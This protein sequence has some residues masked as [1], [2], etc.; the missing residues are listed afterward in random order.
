MIFED[1]TRRSFLKKT[2]ALAVGISAT[3]LFSGLAHAAD[4]GEVALDCGN[5]GGIPKEGDTSTCWGNNKGKNCTYR[6]G[7]GWVVD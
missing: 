7:R 1:S 6:R 5:N 2:T 4:S 3:T